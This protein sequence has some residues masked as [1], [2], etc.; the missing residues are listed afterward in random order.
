MSC[1]AQRSFLWVQ[2]GMDVPEFCSLCS[3]RSSI[4]C[5]FHQNVATCGGGAGIA[6]PKG[7]AF[8]PRWGAEVGS[9]F[10]HCSALLCAMSGDTQLSSVHTPLTLSQ[11]VSSCSSD[12]WLDDVSPWPL[13]LLTWGISS[14]TEN[15]IH[16]EEC[17]GPRRL[18]ASHRNT[19]WELESRRSGSPDY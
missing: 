13:T 15:R 3:L 5:C 7:N 4:L 11:D 6:K 16:C 19:V 1:I 18:R 17:S 8:K 2:H 9:F 12:L 10:I 14:C